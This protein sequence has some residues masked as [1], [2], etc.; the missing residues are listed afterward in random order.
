VLVRVDF[1]VPIKKGKVADDFRLKAAMPTIDYLH[2]KKAKIILISHFKSPKSKAKSQK[3]KFSLRPIADYLKIKFV[4]DC[5]GKNVIK[6]IDELKPGEI[7]LLENLRFYKQEKKNDILFAKKLSSLADVYVNEAFSVCH[8]E[9]ASIVSLPKFLPAYTGLR[10]QTEVKELKQVL[11]TKKSLLVLLG[12]KKISTKIA[13][14]KNLAKKAERILIGGAMANNFLK[15]LGF[16]IGS[17]FYES[18]L[19]KETKIILKKYYSKIILPIDVKVK[20]KNPRRRAFGSLRGRQKSKLQIKNINIEN[21]DKIRESFQILDIGGETINLFREKIRQARMIVWNG[22]MGLFEEP[23]FAQGT[24]MIGQALLANHRAKKIVGGGETIA[25][26]SLHRSGLCAF[27]D[28]NNL[29][30]ST[31][32]GAMLDFLAGKK[33]P[34]LKA[35]NPVR[36]LRFEDEIDF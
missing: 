30:I 4:N 24:K 21:L 28:K 18:E 20:I 12:G 3:S 2:K 26:L 25:S 5:L 16:K 13:A 36:S 11:K 32:G 8:R 19:L 1:N 9:N 15:V 7:I 6:A 10:L 17:S 31:G 14:L 34:G 29:F 35:L 27:A 23:P 33:L 22:P